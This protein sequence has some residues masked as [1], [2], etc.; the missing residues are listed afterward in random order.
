MPGSVTVAQV[1]LAHF[2]KV[3][4]LAG[5]PKPP[6]MNFLFF[7]QTLHPEVIW[8]VLLFLCF[9]T[10]LLLLRL[11]GATGLY[12]YMGIAMIA[13]NIQVL[14][15]VQ[16]SSFSRPIAL[17]TVLFST[18][19][20][21]TDILTEYYGPKAAK[22]GILLGFSAMSLMTLFMLVTLAFRP[23]SVTTTELS[24]ATENHLHMEALFVPAPALLLAG[25]IA[26]FISQYHD[27]WNF[28][29][30]RRHT[31][32]RHLWFRNN[33][34]T[35]LSAFIDNCVFSILAWIVF[36]QK[37]LSWEVVFFTY[38]L[39]TYWLRV[40]VSILDTPILYMAR[41]CLPAKQ[42]EIS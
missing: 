2:V 26:Y 18:T 19:F 11:F 8:I 31:K 36:A 32:G 35:L 20:L 23:L 34:S 29:F 38:I 22:K 17:G 4:I 42:H 25:T 7:L 6:S 9:S 28:Q 40:V 13:A 15:A 10:I 14:K 41:H 37:P 12:L 39:G 5:Q 30:W 33:L 21:C 27:I 24:W 3:R 16:F 1:T